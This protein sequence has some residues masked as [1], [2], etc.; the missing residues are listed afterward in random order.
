MNSLVPK[1]EFIGIANV[2]HLAAG[3]ETPPLRSHLEAIGRFLCDKAD[4]MPGRERMAAVARRAKQGIAVLL[5][6]R[7]GEIAFLASASEG[8]FV[9]AAGIDWRAGD[10]V[11]V[12]RAEYPSVRDVW[13]SPHLPAELRTV[14]SGP[15]ASLSD[16][17]EAANARTRVIAV[18]HVSY[19][20]GARRDLSAFRDLA[21]RVGARLVVDA[22]HAL[23]I[24]PV[25]G[26][27]C[28]AVASCTYKFLLAT[29]GV[30]VLF[31]NGD[32]WPDLAPPWV[33]WHSVV[34]KDWTE[35]GQGRYEL[36][37]DAE[38]FEIGNLGFLNVYVLAN[39]LTR[40]ERLG[41]SNI[42]QHILALGDELWQGLH[43]LG[44]PVITPRDRSCRAGNICFAAAEPDGIAQQLRR[45]G[46]LVWGSEGRVRCSVHAYNDSADVQRV[47][48]ALTAASGG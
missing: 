8:L 2:A 47:L 12:E 28:D 1:D 4:G 10:N 18:S 32:R 16:F 19:L 30:G 7:E 26:S 38:R 48:G 17:R 11:V 44:L 25:D 40:L 34:S 24:V 31:V 23:G 37:K 20:S 15:V 14:G 33:G 39:A 21:D 5:G 45:K 29:H 9:A 27:L 6:R 46:V 43:G 36:K 13:Q 41:A 3:G 42:E 35:R 22:S